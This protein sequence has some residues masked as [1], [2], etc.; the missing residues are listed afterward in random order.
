MYHFPNGPLLFY[1]QQQSHKKD[2]VLN[3]TLLCMTFGTV[4]IVDSCLESL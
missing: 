2:S 1:N 3:Y 4:L